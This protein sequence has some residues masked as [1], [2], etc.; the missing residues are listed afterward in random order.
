[1]DQKEVLCSKKTMR[2]LDD[3]IKVLHT[4]RKAGPIIKDSKYVFIP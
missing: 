4:R 2:K 1:M 3:N